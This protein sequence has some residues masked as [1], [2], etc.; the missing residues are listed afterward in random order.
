[1]L[2]LESWKR[3]KLTVE[4]DLNS[5][6]TPRKDDVLEETVMIAECTGW[7]ELALEVIH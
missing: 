7:F 4:S 5:L 3:L 6:P 2:R 1:M